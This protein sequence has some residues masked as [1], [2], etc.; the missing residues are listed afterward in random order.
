M[1]THH[2]S[3]LKLPVFFAKGIKFGVKGIK[4]GVKGIKFGVKSIKFG[5]E[6]FLKYFK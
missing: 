5:V 1:F 2:S 6:I 4:F 3:P